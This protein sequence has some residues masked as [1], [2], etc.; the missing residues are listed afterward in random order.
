M[1]NNSANDEKVMAVKPTV[2]VLVAVYNASQWIAKCLDSLMRQTLQNIQIICVDDCSTDNSLQLLHGYAGRD[3]RIEVIHLDENKG[4]AHARNVGLLYANGDYICLLDADDWLS[5][6]AL[7]KAVDVFR[8]YPRTGCV[9]FDLMM[10]YSDRSEPY[11]MPEFDCLSGREA[12]KLSLPWKIHGYYVTDSSIHKSFPYDESGELFSDEN[13]THIHYFISG[14]VRRCSGVYYYLQNDKSST[15]IVSRRRFDV[16]RSNRSMR[17]QM[18]EL[19]VD[20]EIIDSYE[21]ER[22]LHLVDMYMLYHCHGSE[23]SL[24][25]RAYA[26]GEIKEAWHDIDKTKIDRSVSSKFGYRPTSSFALFRLQEWLYFTV[27]GIM[28][29]NA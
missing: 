10:V 7:E 18:M 6:D 1:E 22:W 27:R 16:L 13:T 11:E 9:L 5:D 29:K 8:K 15:H 20:K 28:G 17:R 23:L 24:P 14:E 2:T 19:E 26:L 12:L 21:T 3:K 25:D 4:Q